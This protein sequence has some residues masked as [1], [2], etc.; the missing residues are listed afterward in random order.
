MSQY[1]C[2]LR[3]TLFYLQNCMFSQKKSVNVLQNEPTLI[4]VLVGVVLFISV[5]VVIGLL[6]F[7]ADIFNWLQLTMLPICLTI[8]AV[9]KFCTSTQMAEKDIRSHNKIQI[10][11][12]FLKVN[13]Y[14]LI[15]TS[16][17][18]W[19]TYKIDRSLW[20]EALTI[21]DYA[22]H[23]N[24]FWTWCTYTATSLFSK[25]L[26]LNYISQQVRKV[27]WTVSAIASTGISCGFVVVV[28]AKHSNWWIRVTC[29]NSWQSYMVLG[30]IGVL[31]SISYIS[32]FTMQMHLTNFKI[33]I[34]GIFS[35]IYKDEYPFT[36]KVDAD[37]TGNQHKPKVYL[38]TTMYREAD[39]EME[40]FIKSLKIIALSDDIHSLDLECHI[41]I[42]NGIQQRQINRFAKQF[43]SL[44]EKEFLEYGFSSKSFNTPY[45]MQI[46]RHINER[47]P[48]YI[49]LKDSTKV[50]AKKRWSQI[51]YLSYVLNFRNSKPNRISDKHIEAEYNTSNTEC[52]TSDLSYNYDMSYVD[53]RVAECDTANVYI[54]ATD[55]DMTFTDISVLR[56]VKLCEDNPS[57]G[58][59]C[60][61]T[62]PLG[63]APN[64]LVWFQKFEYA[65]GKLYIKFVI[66]EVFIIEY[67][68]N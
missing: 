8:F 3:L 22:N 40:D 57:Y 47:I 27:T 4:P 31:W 36:A 54:L 66:I 65:L 6:L 56:L 30:L 53:E 38:C 2:E 67:L 39:F 35:F 33:N 7:L 42:D 63:K 25:F 58:G 32:M 37:I 16:Y 64:P 5:I 11:Y 1:I 19:Q 44:L 51:M 61:N 17:L 24:V 60:G 62:H 28:C 41:F 13:L 12:S 52:G 18:Y 55:T 34:D 43:I 9:C 20:N 49:Y 21:F 15:A 26:T 29:L 10:V 68:L 46:Q 45:G 14:I 48:L 23:T 50:K 59:A